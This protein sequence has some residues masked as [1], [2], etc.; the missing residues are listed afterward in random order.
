MR[1]TS[2]VVFLWVTIAVSAT[3]V[4]AANP[5]NISN[6]HLN[7][8]SLCI[9]RFEISMK[10]GTSVVL[11]EEVV[12]DV[13]NS[14]GEAM[15]TAFACSKPPTPVLPPVSWRSIFSDRVQPSTE[16]YSS[17]STWI[18][19]WYYPASTTGRFPPNK[20][21]YD[22][23]KRALYDVA[24]KQCIVACADEFPA[25]LSLV[26]FLAYGVCHCSTAMPSTSTVLN[27][28]AAECCA[29][30]DNSTGVVV[31]P[32]K[33]PSCTTGALHG[34]LLR[35]V[36]SCPLNASFC[37]STSTA[38]KDNCKVANGCCGTPQL[39]DPSDDS[40]GISSAEST[41]AKWL[42][43]LLLVAVAFQL[44]YW[45]IKLRICDRGERTDG[46]AVEAAANRRNARR[47]RMARIGGHDVAIE[48]GVDEE[49]ED[50][51][52]MLSQLNEIARRM[53][54]AFIR[55][56]Q[57]RAEPRRTKDEALDA[58]LEALQLFPTC[59]QESVDPEES[60]CMCL[61]AL[62]E[63]ECVRVLCGH[64]IH[65]E[66]MKEFLAHKL[67]SYRCPVTCPMCRATV[68]LQN[69]SFD[70][71]PSSVDGSFSRSDAGVGVPSTEGALTTGLLSHG[72]EG[73]PTERRQRRRGHSRGRRFRVALA[74]LAVERLLEGRRHEGELDQRTSLDA[75]PTATWADVGGEPSPT[76]VVVDVTASPP[77]QAE[78]HMYATDSDQNLVPTFSVNDL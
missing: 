60:C 65:R 27:A 67:T 6:G 47:R 48:E 37:E 77:V 39:P 45:V 3:A 28:S 73:A 59:P 4:L 32:P 24:V 70:S 75:L 40:G 50:D 63:R 46:P 64:V 19:P 38:V 57:Q 11:P 16:K 13:P 52:D 21:I 69:A 74:N 10:S 36:F 56:Q 17:N 5:V 68:L 61:D 42:V 71:L 31:L 54:L 29:P 1:S 7:P 55:Q 15:I 14:I 53:R 72:E 43:G 25:S 35:V 58:A 26:V 51:G 33:P 41:A 8:P 23:E 62:C 34:Q 20:T 49:L 78:Q 18:Q 76:S 66:C 9:N 12:V 2:H 22:E 30:V 44:G